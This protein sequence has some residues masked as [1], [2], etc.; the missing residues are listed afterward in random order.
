MALTVII[1]MVL[2]SKFTE[3]TEDTG[4]VKFK[5]GYNAEIIEYVGDWLNQ[6]INLFTQHMPHTKS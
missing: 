6:L 1:S 4:V 3:D 2:V 5:K